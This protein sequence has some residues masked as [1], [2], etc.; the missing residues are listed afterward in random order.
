MQALTCIYAATRAVTNQDQPCRHRG[1]RPAESGRCG[2][3]VG[4]NRATPSALGSAAGRR[5]AARRTHDLDPVPEYRVHAGGMRTSEVARRARVN[6]QTLR[7]YE[8]RGLLPEPER[9]GSGYRAYAPEA[10]RVVRFVK[11]AGAGVHPGRGRGTARV[12]GRRSGQ[13]CGGQGPGHR[14]DRRPAGTDC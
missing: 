11:R 2:R 13:L 4:P 12:R 9:T 6:P 3:R 8:R 10:V 1:S 5:R 7:Y 14:Q